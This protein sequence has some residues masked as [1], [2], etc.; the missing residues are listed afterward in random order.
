MNSIKAVLI[1]I[2]WLLVAV[3]CFLLAAVGNNPIFSLPCFIT[4]AVGI[5]FLLSGTFAKD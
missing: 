3:L 4:F 2:G 1:G 5:I